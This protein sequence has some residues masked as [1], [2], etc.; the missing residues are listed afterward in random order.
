[1]TG[2]LT[3]PLPGEHDPRSVMDSDDF[4][5]AQLARFPIGASPHRGRD[6]LGMATGA[7]AA[8]ALGAITFI[9]L[10][11]QRNAP[12]ANPDQAIVANPG[13][14]VVTASDG[15]MTV[16]TAAITPLAPGQPHAPMSGGA[17]APP[18]VMMGNPVAAMIDRDR[19]PALIMDNYGPPSPTVSASAGNGD[20]GPR[21]AA[22]NASG[23][24]DS[25][26]FAQRLS[27]SGVERAIA[28]RMSDPGRTV[29][30]GTLIAAVL[31]TAINSDLPGYVRAF[32]SQDVRGFDN[33]T[34]LI[35]RGSR[36]IGQ[37]K[38]GVSAGQTRAYVLWTRLIRPDGASVSIGSPGTDVEGETGLP[39]KVNSHFMKRFGAAIL[40]SIVGGVASTGS[41]AVIIS[42]SQS[43]A[44]VA[45]QST[46]DIPPTIRVGQGQPIRVFTARDL[47]F[48]KVGN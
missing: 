7:A 20:A 19:A 16:P 21:A 10:S 29:V 11:S 13:S 47:D 2:R 27:D 35:P 41:K 42:G 48:S 25:E 43:A 12:P 28:A 22:A 5:Q 6:G 32:V 40:L 14:A 45:A 9:S 17:T 18:P 46:A 34:V 23:L 8:L 30:Q 31:E 4:E 26:R 44:S 33:S 24:N 3:D 39:G 36:L 15:S 1:M 38:S 37:Y